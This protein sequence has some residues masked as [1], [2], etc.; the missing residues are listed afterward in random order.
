MVIYGIY[1]FVYIVVSI[2]DQELF[3]ARQNGPTFFIRK[4]NY[5]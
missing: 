5:A 2:S 4:K 1:E 3:L